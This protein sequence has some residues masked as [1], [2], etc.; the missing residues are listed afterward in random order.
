MTFSQHSSA[1]AV[2]TSQVLSRLRPRTAWVPAV[3]LLTLLLPT[4]T[5]VMLGGLRLSAY[6]VV[7]LVLFPLLMVRVYAGRLPGPRV[8]DWLILGNGVW[9][10]VALTVHHGIERATE[11]GG[12]YIVECVGAYALARTYV[13]SPEAYMGVVRSLFGILLCILP[14]V[15]IESVTGIHVLRLI[16]SGGRFSS[17]IDQRFGL[18]R[19]FGPFDHPI[20]LGTFAASAVAMLWYVFGDRKRLSKRGITRTGFAAIAAATS[21]SSGAIAAMMIQL[22]LC[23]WE[24]FTRTKPFRWAVFALLVLTAYVAV[25][26][27]SNRSGMKVFLSY[28]TFSP[29]T[30]YDRLIIWEWGFYKN[31]LA[32]PVFGIG[33]NVWTRPSWM[34]STSMDNFWLVQMVSYG[35]PACAMLAAATIIA[36][37]ARPRRASSA[38]LYIRTGWA[39]SLIGVSVAGCTVHFWNHLL[40]WFFFLLGLGGAFHRTERKRSNT[41]DTIVNRESAALDTSVPRCTF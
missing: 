20:L 3:F 21:L 17:A 8:A 33:E 14:L 22:I 37:V 16:F 23:V 38:V 1:Q 27:V 18:T 29:G 30:A 5:S 40:V 34:H 26:L 36:L 41:T 35:I 32:H 13:R 24:R 4:D 11:A 12:I 15:V 25:D 7:L 19:A 2:P 39:I 31:A 28:L 6:R 10:F 9:A